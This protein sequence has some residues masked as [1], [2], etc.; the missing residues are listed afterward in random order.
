MKSVISL[1]IAI[2]LSIGA[3]SAH[4]PEIHCKHFFYGYPHG[5]P[6]TNDLIIR[7][8]Y[9]LSS[10]DETK[11][12]D[13]V[14]FR[15]D[16]ATV[17]GDNKEDRVWKADPWLAEQETLEPADYKN[18]N[19]A[20]KVDRGH[21]AP[22]ASFKG[23]T[24]GFLTNYLSNITPQQSILNQGVWQRLE[25]KMRALIEEYE[26]V[27]VMTGPLYERH[28]GQLPN[29]DE[30][31][32]IPS[33]YWQIVFVEPEKNFESIQAAAFIFDQET[34]GD[35]E[36]LKYLVTI[37]EV[38]ERSK[39]NFL[40]ELSPVLESQTESELHRNWAEKHF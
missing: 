33:G 32:T 1:L 14:A 27:Y 34:A 7:D 18:A 15:L 26:A 23:T 17:D 29:A 3:V 25:G 10:N 35:D 19:K 36:I 6:E 4:E 22:L 40:S 11:F 39:L 37:D 5:T 31:H 30:S 13:W 28:M 24:M 21:Q 16:K 8:I 2:S 12:S 9:A 20:L 38:E